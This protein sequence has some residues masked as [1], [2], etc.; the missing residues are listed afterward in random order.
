VDASTSKILGSARRLRDRVACA[1]VLTV[2]AAAA[3]APAA[4]AAEGLP[5]RSADSFV[6]SIGVNTH[7]FFN[8]TIY[9][10]QFD[11]VKQ[12]LAELGVR[13][14]RED[15]VPDRPDQYERLNELA[16]MGIRSTLI[17]GDP[18][19]GVE[20]LETLTS[21]LSSE[22]RGAVEAIEGPNEF[23]SRGGSD[24]QPRLSDY[25]QRLYSLV[26]SDPSLAAL[27]VVGPSI[28][29]RRN[30]EA[31]GDISGALDYGNIHSYPDGYSP[32]SNL[33]AHLER[34][35]N[36][37]GSE[38][39]LATETGYH[40]TAG[41]T[42]EHNP[43]SERAMAI[44]TPRMFLEYFR[45]GVA[46]TFSYELLDEKPDRGEREHNFG[47]L[48]NDFSEKPAFA[49]L[50]NL[51]DILEDPG[52]A[53][54]PTALDY[55]LGGDTED[56]HDVL[57]QK[58]DGSFYLALWRARDVWDPVAQTD[59]EVPSGRVSVEL[60]RQLLSAE[61]Y[62]PNVSSSPLG[63][64]SSVSGRPLVV[65]VGAEIVI[66]KLTLGK[67]TSGRIKVWLS[68]RTV[69]AGGRV[70]VKGR[71]PTTSTGR[72]IPVKIQRWWK[73]SWRTIG[74]DRTSRAGIFR[75]KI[76]LPARSAPRA[77]RLRV[78]ARTAKPSRPVR[79]RI[80]R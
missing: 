19:D 80:R 45:T 4:G 72:R 52:P 3:F 62:A 29:Q 69:P 9:Y 55:S 47:L 16:G 66:V 21:I 11:L 48:R 40:T 53:F 56:L 2:A 50:R 13:H 32:E 30:Q 17:M 12:R 42:G 22:L 27:P 28:V 49:A 1:A 71:L 39:V 51:I 44:Y 5:A 14:V 78:V 23:D 77:S 31:L 67:K 34:G 43:T 10:S 7:T 36:N 70:A 73:G 61:T 64:I 38:P 75:K 46:R 41:W 25:Q 76:R 58:R 26:K 74:R 59:L 20:G 60:D 68:K 15:L 54:E 57:L 8:D 35:A 6:D 63:S 37:S 24:W 33:T 65:D 79:V 18:D